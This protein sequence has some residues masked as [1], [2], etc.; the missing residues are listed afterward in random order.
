MTDEGVSKVVNQE[1]LEQ[2]EEL[3]QKYKY[4]WGKEVELNN[5]I[6]NMSQEQLVAVLERIVETGESVL[7]GWDKC[8]AQRNK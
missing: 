5:S 7:V 2:I 6:P 3:L 1:A 8:F 4:N